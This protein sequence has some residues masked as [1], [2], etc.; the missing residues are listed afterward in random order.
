MP[1]K[2]NSSLM[3]TEIQFNHFLKK[4]T[5]SSSKF[6]KIGW[7]SNNNNSNSCCSNSKWQISRDF[8][9]L[10]KRNTM[11]ST[12]VI[13]LPRAF[14]KPKMILLISLQGQCQVRSLRVVLQFVTMLHLQWLNKKIIKLMTELPNKRSNSQ[15]FWKNISLSKRLPSKSEWRVPKFN[16]RVREETIELKQS[17]NASLKKRWLTSKEV[18]CSR[19]TLNR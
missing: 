8:H 2:A 14:Q 15:T 16:R 7:Y 17:N 1:K 5:F 13:F 18:R 3:K 11:D 6:F 4:S 10:N 9:W 19:G 12:S